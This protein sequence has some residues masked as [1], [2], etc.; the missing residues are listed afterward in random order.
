MAETSRRTG[1][2]RL[3]DAELE[4]LDQAVCRWGSRASYRAEIFSEQYNRPSH[5]LDDA[6][7]NETLDCFEKLGWITG[8]TYSSPWS[9]T[10]RSVELTPTGGQ[11]WE[12]ER[13][14]DWGRY[15]MDTGGA[16]I[17]NELRRHRA[18]IFGY[19]PKSVRK[20]FEIGRM[21]GFFGLTAGP[22]RTAAAVRK[23]IYWRE[24]QT[25]YLLSSWIESWDSYPDWE[26]MESMRTWWRFPDEIGKL[27]GLPSM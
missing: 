16:W 5:G 15:V 21:C 19:S 10:D 22:I 1:V 23:W 25:V 2:T 12:S 26:R 7:L 27:W 6:T 13:L 14:P 8:R 20:F 24:P 4:L 9:E 11:L 18:S 17:T 3:T